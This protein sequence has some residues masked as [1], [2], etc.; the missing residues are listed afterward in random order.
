MSPACVHAA[1][2]IQAMD[3]VF[4]GC[5]E[6]LCAPMESAC[7]V[8]RMVLNRCARFGEAAIWAAPESYQKGP[9]F[10]QHGQ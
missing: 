8:E 5:S 2:G 10:G 1:A 6:L 9:V 4:E 7:Q 3:H